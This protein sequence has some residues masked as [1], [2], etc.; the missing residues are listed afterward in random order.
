MLSEHP[1]S[2][3]LSEQQKRLWGLQQRDQT[4][5]VS[6]CCLGLQGRIDP[7]HLLTALQKIVER[8]SI[9][10][11]VFA[12]SPED[13]VIFQK[14]QDDVTIDWEQLDWRTLDEPTRKGRLKEA[15]QEWRKAGFDLKSGPVVRARTIQRDEESFELVLMT[16]SLCSDAASLQECVMEMSREWAGVPDRSTHAMQYNEYAEWQHKLRGD[17]VATPAGAYWHRIQNR[18]GVSEE[19]LSFKSPA[20]EDHGWQV[21]TAEIAGQTAR[22]LNEFCTRRKSSLE[23][24]L[25]ACWQVML[26][27]LS[28]QEKVGFY[29]CCRRTRV[30]NSGEL[31]GPLER[32]LPVPNR[33]AMGL[34]VEEVVE[35]L[36]QYIHD[37]AEWQEYWS[38]G[39][40]EYNIQFEY[41]DEIPA[42]TAG[43]VQFV[44]NEVGD[45]I[46]NYR[47]KLCCVVGAQ[48]IRT[49]LH[50]DRRFFEDE[51]VAH[52][53]PQWGQLLGLAVN[54]NEKIENLKI[55][56]D[57]EW[58]LIL[59]PYTS[60]GKLN[61]SESPEPEQIRD[62]KQW[63]F[64]APH[65]Q[66]EELIAGV[67]AEVLGLKRVSIDSN[68]FDLGGQSILAARII[69]RL[70][71]ALN[72]HV[73]PQAMFEGGTVARLAEWIKNQT[74]QVKQEE[75]L[76]ITPAP[77]NIRLPLTAAQER[78]WFFD[79]LS[80]GNLAYTLV[81]AIR[82]T[83]PL[84]LGAMQ[85]SLTE[86]VRRHEVLRTTF[87]VFRGEPYQQVYP[88]Q[89]IE[90]NIM[91]L[92]LHED[93]EREI[94]GC[95]ER[96]EL[97]P[98]NLARGPLFRVRVW[99]LGPQSHVAAFAVHHIIFDAWSSGVMVRE[100]GMLYEAFCKGSAASLPDLPIQ[101][102]DFAYWEK[103]ALKGQRL[104]SRMAFW[105][106][107]FKQPLPHFRLKGDYPRPEMQTFRGAKLDFEISPEVMDA[108]KELG[109]KQGTTLFMTLLT[110]FDFLMYC[111]S[112]QTDII[113]GTDVANRDKVETEGLIGLFANQI[114]I[115]CDLSGN[116]TFLQLLAQV[117]RTTLSA[118]SHQE[119]PLDRIITE[120]RL[121][122][123]AQSTPLF[124][125][126]M[127]LV[128]T[129][130][131]PFQ[132]FGLVTEPMGFHHA[133]AKLDIALLLH[134]YPSGLK[135][136]YEYNSDLFAPQTIAQMAARF[137]LVLRRIIQNPQITLAESVEEIE[138][139]DAALQVAATRQPGTPSG[140]FPG[141]LQNAQGITR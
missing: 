110:A 29:R 141:V 109:R 98:F 130:F 30:D 28:N 73:T 59:T 16:P 57:S 38:A 35:E 106:K 100:M 111:Y 52:L 139:W 22:D 107:Q 75:E 72:V 115:R 14:V 25:L 64:V 4:I 63:Q 132:L 9:L 94:R 41:R 66:L 34:R 91:D 56:S 129:P 70:R 99:K 137:E 65:T 97:T 7:E 78:L 24:V 104:D 33:L 62:P 108:V 68:F 92:S 134:E 6:W 133:F 60:S 87:P 32:F 112:A 77:R 12:A 37:A 49:E 15:Q 85:K 42:G 93:R 17:A 138:K 90:L 61:R 89:P 43:Q 119:V 31:R 74:S 122:R 54:S 40:G 39:K 96:E 117:R 58:E 81:Q 105:R 2:G 5:R 125:V 67:W 135:G 18:S 76:E 126:K 50:Y 1:R 101:Y 102:V 46:E 80:P 3:V 127:E 120:L 47:L 26:W 118:Y 84:D 48:G 45:E 36:Q 69:T 95:I 121:Q 82:M 86:L 113:V 53:L 103:Q 8:H 21:Q 124:Q 88:P 44:I 13:G 128:N 71:Q 116:P 10:R 27:K 20:E 83:G 19:A 114:A 23:A 140:G 131:T 79:Q 136:W 11:T 55:S 51:S 123:S